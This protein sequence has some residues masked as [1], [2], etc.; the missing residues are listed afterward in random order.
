MSTFETGQFVVRA[1]AIIVH[2]GRLLVVRHAHN[3]SYSALPGGH[4]EWGETPHGGLIREIEEEL[5][6][7]P[8]VGSLLYVNTFTQERGGKP[9][10]PVEFFFQIDNPKDFHTLQAD[11]L[12]SHAHELSSVEWIEAGARSDLLPAQLAEDWAS[13]VLTVAA[14]SGV[15]FIQH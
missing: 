5:G 11:S 8:V 14:T 7:T 3:P 12:R 10:Q 1:R 6:V 9:V 2:E 15:H 4:L 13:G